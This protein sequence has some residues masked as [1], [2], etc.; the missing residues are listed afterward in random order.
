ME[1]YLAM[2]RNK[3]LVNATTWVNLKNIM[4]SG[5][6]QSQKTTYLMILFITKCPK[7][8]NLYRENRLVVA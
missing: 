3:V 6:N 4:Q 2:K 1:Y 8:A 7:K 5:R